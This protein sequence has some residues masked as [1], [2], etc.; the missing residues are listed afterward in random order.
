ME[1]RTMKHQHL[2]E[3]SWNCLLVTQRLWW[4]SP[5]SITQNR[6]SIFIFS[7]KGV[8]YNPPKR[9]N[10]PFG[11]NMFLLSLPLKIRFYLKLWVVIRLYHE[12][13]SMGKRDDQVVVSNIFYFH[14]YLGIWSNLTKIFQ[15]GWNHQLGFV[16]ILKLPSEVISFWISLSLGTNFL[17][18][19]R[20]SKIQVSWQCCDKLPTQVLV[21]KPK[22][23][24]PKMPWIFEQL[25]SFPCLFAGKKVTTLPETNSINHLKTG[26]LWSFRF[27]ARRANFQGR[28]A[29]VSFREGIYIP[30]GSRHEAIRISWNVSQ[31]FRRLLIC[32]CWGVAISEFAHWVVETWFFCHLSIKKVVVD[33]RAAL[34]VSNRQQVD[35][36]G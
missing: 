25:P 1:H 3:N 4:M 31:G 34:N 18:G 24:P 22:K 35:K 28:T 17:L 2:V 11:R 13:V 9:D 29:A 27:G 36:R 14:P 19:F 30:W 12:N 6:W 33:L 15:M 32:F 16:D 23:K 10:L 5:L 8:V 20:M 7:P 26:W 21:V